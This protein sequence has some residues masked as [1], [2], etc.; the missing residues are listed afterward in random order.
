[1][2]RMFVRHRVA[3]FE[4]WKKA[5]DAF[6][7]ERRGLG[8]FDDA[9][10]RSADDPSEVTA[11]HDFETLEVAKNFA[12]SPRLREIMKNAGV[13]GEPSIWFASRA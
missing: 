4:V 1:M 8:V 3:D 11:W 10:F 7:S 12:G 5:Y 2:V 6:D 13:T 9:V